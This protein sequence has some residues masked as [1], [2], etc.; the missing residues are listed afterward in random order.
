MYT[1]KKRKSNIFL[2]LL[3][4]ALVIP[5]IVAAQYHEPTYDRKPANDHEM[6]VDDTTMNIF[7]IYP[8]QTDGELNIVMDDFV[9]KPVEILIQDKKG[10]TVL[11]QRIDQLNIG[12]QW[13]NLNDYD[14]AS[15][16]YTVTVLNS[17]NSFNAETVFTRKK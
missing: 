7:E 4:L 5:Q 13:L 15:G 6:L 2:Q 9:G 1:T 14:L 10:N 17:E 11:H 16:K 12:Y 8:A 3:I